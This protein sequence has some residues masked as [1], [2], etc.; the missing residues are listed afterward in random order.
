VDNVAVLVH[1]LCIILWK[2]K[3]FVHKLASELGK[4]FEQGVEQKYFAAS[5][6]HSLNAAERMD[7][8]PGTLSAVENMP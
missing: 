3:Y 7:R 1:S 4:L 2:A 6:I 5:S 8:P